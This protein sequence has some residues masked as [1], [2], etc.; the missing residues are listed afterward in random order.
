MNITEAQRVELETVLDEMVGLI[1]RRTSEGLRALLRYE[2]CVT[3]LR[4]AQPGH[5]RLRCDANSQKPRKDQNTL[6]V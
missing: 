2:R 4:E 6:T 3:W 5:R 1:D